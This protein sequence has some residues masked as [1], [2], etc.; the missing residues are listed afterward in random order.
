MSH[1]IEMMDA[2]KLFEV[3]MTQYRQYLA[4]NPDPHLEHDYLLPLSRVVDVGGYKGDW[5]AKILDKYGP[6]VDVFEPVKEFV[7]H[8]RTRFQGDYRVSIHPVALED[9]HE[10]RQIFLDEDS[11]SF[12]PDVKRQRKADIIVD[13]I[14]TYPL[15]GADL[16]SINAEGSEYKILPRLIETK[17]IDLF[18]NV[19]VQFH[20]TVPGAN[21]LRNEIR[22]KLS[23]THI[24]QY[25]FPF[26]W[27]SWRR[28]Y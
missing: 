4:D 18:K 12:F 16:I 24:Q 10:L 8:L 25:C 5:T 15:G 2:K 20:W 17:M 6:F 21:D 3:G 19:Q 7:K 27:E 26:V 14:A 28:K 13:D 23:K 22:E 9:K 1:W 11:S